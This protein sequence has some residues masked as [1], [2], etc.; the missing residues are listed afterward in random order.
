MTSYGCVNH[1]GYD[2]LVSPPV[3]GPPPGRV[4]P[5]RRL[6]SI[7]HAAVL[8]AVIGV[9]GTWRSAAP[10]SLNGVEGPHDG[11]L[12]IIFALVA[13]A[14]VRSLS[15]EGWLGIVTVVAAAGAMLYTAVGNLLDDRAVLGGSSGWG[16]WLSIGAAVVLVGTA[17]WAAFRRVHGPVAGEVVR[18]TTAGSS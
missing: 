7:C 15:R 1:R 8:L 11:W 13:L 10:V 5:D 2:W 4:G 12:V 16:L 18:P 6:A 17:L 14:G 9:F 3:D